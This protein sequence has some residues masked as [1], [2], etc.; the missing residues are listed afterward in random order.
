MRY[1]ILLCLFVPVYT[2]ADTALWRVSKG[3][4]ELY[5]GGTIHVLSA[6]DY[7][8][9]AEFEKAYQ[10][11]QLLVLETDMAAMAKPEVQGKLLQLVM[12]PPGKTLKDDLKD[13][14]YSALVEYAEASG[15]M[16]QSL[17]QFKPSM[18]MITL[19][20][21]ELQRLGMANSGVDSYFHNKALSEGKILGELETV[22]VQLNVIANLGK[23]HE[24]EL[25][26]N[27]LD[28]M[29]QLSLTMNDLKKAWRQGDL[30]QLEALG[31]EQMK[32][33]YPELYEILLVDRNNAWMPKIE[34]MLLT[35]E[36]EFVLMGALHLVSS[37][38]VVSKL[39]KRGYKVERF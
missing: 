30:K 36:V 19:L 2:F 21:T 9:P 32:Q 15:L 18:V 23:G 25:I 6:S 12:Y 38:G 22:E 1:L 3:D 39:R 35:P 16:M 10:L 17:N 26:L 11:S 4:A 37:D 31:L 8:L 7:P 20:M 28:E 13:E 27:T 24:D 33:D 14:T 34:A 29:K 5:L